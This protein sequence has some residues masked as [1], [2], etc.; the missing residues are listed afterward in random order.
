[1]KIWIDLA[2]S[3][4]VLFFRPIIAELEAR[5]HQVLITARDFAQTVPLA[6]HYGFNYTEVGDWTTRKSTVTKL[7]KTLR[8]VVSLMGFARGKGMALAVSHNSYSQALA[9]FCLGIPLVTL[10]DY[11]HQP[12]NHVS[13]RLARKVL[14]PMVFPDETLRKCGAR[15]ER[16]EKYKGLKE[17][18]YLADFKPRPGFLDSAGIPQEKVIVCLRPPGTGIYHHYEN[19]VFSELLTYLG[20]QEDVF[21]VLLPRFPEQ[22]QA[23]QARLSQTWIP[24]QVVNG[25]DLIYHSDLVISAVGTMGREAAVLGT[26]AYTVFAGKPGMV[27]GCLM[28]QGKLTHIKGPADFSRI[29]FRKKR[30]AEVRVSNG[31]GLVREITDKILNATEPLKQREERD[32]EVCDL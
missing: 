19:T 14:V 25:P 8:R 11:E 7:T 6:A 10:M 32:H 21:I 9:A 15:P 5:G 30:R 12:A 2:N 17:E 16:V 28:E 31:N 24:P 20:Q 3:P 4:Q 23:L 29:T 18:V 1:M 27:D 13:F 26:P 22:G